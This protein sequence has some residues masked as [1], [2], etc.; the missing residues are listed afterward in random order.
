MV[1]RRDESNAS[2]RRLNVFLC[3]ACK[4]KPAVR[5]LY[6]RLKAAGV[7]PWLDEEDIL[8][9]Q[10]W[11]EVIHEA[12]G[13][14]HVVVVC[15]SK[16]S[17][18][19]EGYVQK[20]IALALDA[21]AL[22]PEKTIFLIPARLEECAIPNRLARWHWVDLHADGGF[23]KLLRS[24]QTRADSLKLEMKP[25]APK[26]VVNEIDGTALILVPAGEFIMGSNA[27]ERNERPQRTV[28][29]DEY[30]IAKY[31]VTN[32]QYKLFVEATQHDEPKYCDDNRYNWPNQPVVG[33]TWH[34]AQAYCEW[35]GLRLPTEAEWEK[36]A[37]GTDG[38]TWPWGNEPPTEKLCNF[39]G[40][41]GTT[42][43]IGSYPEG[44]SPYGCHDM[45]GNVYEWC[46]DNVGD[47][48]K[49]GW[50]NPKGDTASPVSRG[51][52]MNSPGDCVRC[53]IRNRH[54][55]THRFDRVGFRCTR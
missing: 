38:R 28:Y 25:P 37:R 2:E 10:N 17:V 44:T 20:E 24:L 34:D 45:A 32:A 9:G 5:A 41:V 14:S 35:A 49:A 55:P 15:L 26:S 39:D 19:K 23:E 47:C 27:H 1:E 21:E 51:G 12:V 13:G 53:S 16:N 18:D 30:R 36:A 29:L 54:K 7:Q 48:R 50:R 8:P 46:C 33:V 11:E 43:E 6:Q 52:C 4:D 22:M 31:P 42:T 3:H 40:N